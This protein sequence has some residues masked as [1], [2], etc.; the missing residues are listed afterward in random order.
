MDSRKS[1]GIGI[2]MK[3]KKPNCR[4]LEQVDLNNGGGS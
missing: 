3:S 2:S 4:V 1:P